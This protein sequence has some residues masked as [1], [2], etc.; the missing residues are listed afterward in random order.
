MTGYKTNNSGEGLLIEWQIP[1]Q[2]ARYH[3][4]GT[5]FK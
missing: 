4:D 1:V 2:Q 3:K 5:W